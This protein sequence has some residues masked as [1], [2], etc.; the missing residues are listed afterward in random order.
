[1]NNWDSVQSFTAVPRIVFNVLFCNLEKSV[2]CSQCLVP[3]SFWCRDIW[4]LSADFL[5]QCC[6][7][8]LIFKTKVSSSFQWTN[9]EKS[10]GLTMIPTIQEIISNALEKKKALYPGT[11]VF[12]NTSASSIRNKKQSVT[13]DSCRRMETGVGQVW[14]QASSS[15][16]GCNIPVS[17]PTASDIHI[18]QSEQ[19]QL[20]VRAAQTHIQEDG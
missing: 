13:S 18:H 19:T 9:R 3:S 17:T 14:S 16:R 8:T 12:A 20:Q 4:K 15:P 5:S 6:R 10:F 1:M 2:K 7:K 11:D